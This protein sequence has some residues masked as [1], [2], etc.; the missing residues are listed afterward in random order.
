MTAGD[1]KSPLVFDSSPLNYFARSGHLALLEKLVDG[2]ACFMTTVVADEL[3]RGASRHS[4]LHMVGAQPWLTAA[5]DD[6]L[7][8]LRLFAMFHSRLG[9]SS[10]DTKDL[11]EATTLAYAELHHCTA[12][13]DDRAGRNAGIA[14]GVSVSSSL[15]LICH[16]LRNGLIAEESACTVVD[17]LRDAE[18]FFPCDGTTFMG[19][20]R[21]EGLL[22]PA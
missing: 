17:A 15:H 11:G 21:S 20:A 9:G 8:F 4:R 13:I 3:Q 6:S 16:G 12:V 1:P 14:L 2:R 10:R 18:A 22:D 5:S 7:Q 19:W